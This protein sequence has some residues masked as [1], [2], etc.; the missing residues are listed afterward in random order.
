MEQDHNLPKNEDL[1]P[2][3]HDLASWHGSGEHRDDVTPEVKEAGD[4]AYAYVEAREQAEA[5]YHDQVEA[6][7]RQ[8]AELLSTVSKQRDLLWEWHQLAFLMSQVEHASFGEIILGFVGL[9]P[10]VTNRILRD[11]KRAIKQPK[12]RKDAA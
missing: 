2:A 9:D 1:P 5:K 6:Q 11:T 7:R 3:W 12:K 4:A 8:I 10:V